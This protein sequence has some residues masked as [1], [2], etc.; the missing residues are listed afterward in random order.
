MNGIA[1]AGRFALRE[2]RAGVR[3]FVIFLALIALGVAA[4]AAVGSVSRAI[5]REGW[6]AR[7]RR[8]SAAISPS[9]SCSG[10]RRRP[11][12]SSLERARRRIRRSRRCAAWRGGPMAATRRWWRSRPS[13]APFYPLHRHAGRRAGRRERSMPRERPL[14]ALADPELFT[15][16]GLAV[17]DS[18]DL[19]SA[20]LRPRRHD[21]ARA[22]QARH[23]PRLWPAA[24]RHRC[25]ARPRRAGAAGQHRAMGPGRVRL[26]DW[27]QTPAALA[28]RATVAISRCAA[29][30]SAPATTP[31]RGL[32]RNIE[33]LRAI[34]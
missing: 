15:R 16:L 27:R 13:T 4:I 32:K 26:A 7:A 19:G 11:S 9:L 17:G 6:R 34:F 3:G 20:R 14:D 25:S 12:G 10:R 31:R 18:I 2:L 22:G 24:A 1:L 23:R 21:H 8:S 5:D 29:G 33:Q 30:R 28:E